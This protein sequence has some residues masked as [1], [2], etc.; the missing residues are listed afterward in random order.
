MENNNRL[1]EQQFQLLEQG[2]L[3]TPHS[4][5]GLHLIN[6]EERQVVRIFCPN[7]KQIVVEDLKDGN[8]YPLSFKGYQGL[9]EGVI[10]DKKE[11]FLYKVICEDEQG[12]KWSYIDPYQFDSTFTDDDLYLFGLG[13]DYEL[14]HKLGANFIAV[15]GV[16]GIRFAVWAPHAK[17]VSVIGDFN[18][19][20]GRRHP[21]RFIAKQGIW[22]LFVP[23]LVEGDLYKFE[24]HTERGELLYKTDPYANYY[25]LRPNNAA[26]IYDMRRY[27][28]KDTKWMKARAKKAHYKEA[29]SI[30]EVHIGSWKRHA[31]GDFYTYREAADELASYV[32][33]MGYTHIELMGIVEHP[34]DGSWGYQVTGYF[35]P[36]SRYGTPDDFKYFVETMH[37]NNIGVLLDWVP[38]HFPKDAF[39]LE[40]FD[41]RALYE[42]ANETEALHPHWGTLIFDYGKPQVALFLIA[43][44]LSW[45]ERYHI[46]G[47]RVDAVASMLYLDYG[48]E[49]NFIPNQYG[50]KENLEAIA[51]LKHLNEVAYS[52]IPGVMMIAEESTA[53]PKVSHAISEG[54]LGFGFKWNMGWMNDFL[55]YMKT[56]PAKRTREHGK[57]TFSLMYA[58]SENFIQ[59]LSHDEVVHGKAS[60][61]YKMPGDNLEKFAH[62][63]A[64]YGFMY[65]HPGKKMLFMGDEFAQIKEWNEEV[66]LDWDLLN[67]SEHQGITNWVRA[68]NQLY[69]AEKA[70]WETGNGYENF[71]WIDCENREQSIISF[72]RRSVVTKEELIVVINF[73][74]ASY[75]NY[76][77]GVPEL[78]SYNELLNSD[79]LLYGGSHQLN[80][81]VKSTDI[82]W[83]GRPYSIEITIPPLSMMIFKAKKKLVKEK[84][85]TQKNVN[86]KVKEEVKENKSVV[87]KDAQLI[88]SPEE[89]KEKVVGIAAKETKKKTS[90]KAEELTTKEKTTQLTNEEGKKIKTKRIKTEKTKENISQIKK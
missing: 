15:D 62:L 54:G 55:S 41:G 33:V 3:A 83:H 81:V 42:K 21:M 80:G 24:I 67:Y 79:D 63:R 6:Q 23:G 12:H 11:K 87:R 61:I 10:E 48:R 77:I 29:V 28:W 84:D 50:G 53:W 76:R 78:T 73:Q 45:L 32:K 85:K 39:A 51:F 38:A 4:I 19:W 72:L 52:R 60:M 37:K 74:T 36:T 89:K 65:A 90:N 40:K 9:F 64:A 35:A 25:E 26:V 7:A 18:N 66:A 70:L 75:T 43:S 31:N 46:D 8:N 1:I 58:F 20:D 57:I 16:T 47:L 82:G 27:K 69:K 71:E 5:L 88:K 44:A 49:G 13:K 86:E 2:T 56:P 68:L 17:R 34:F 22:E 30:Y 14:H 59:V